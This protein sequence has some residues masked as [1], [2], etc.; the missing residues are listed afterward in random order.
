V[1]Q[2]LFP[3]AARRLRAHL[4]E[5]FESAETAADIDLLRQLVSAAQSQGRPSGRV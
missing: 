1:T 2:V 5:T 3:Y 4:E